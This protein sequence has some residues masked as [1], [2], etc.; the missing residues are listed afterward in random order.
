MSKAKV[1][2]WIK[3]L[4]VALFTTAICTTAYAAAID[5]ILLRWRKTSKYEDATGNLTIAV[6]YYSA[7]LVEAELQ[8]EAEKNLWTQDE[9]ERY[10]YRYLKTLN[11]AEMIPIK[12]EFVN[13]GPTMYPGPFD[14][15]IKMQIG[16]KTYEP[17]DYDKRF[18]FSFQGEK[19]GLVFF[20]RF[21][22]KT[23]KNLLDGKH[24]DSRTRQTGP[25]LLGHK[26][27][28]PVKALRGTDRRAP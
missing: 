20:N 23:G 3:I 8:S 11:L 19:D 27:R 16:N 15:M 26:E 12:V 10:K 6:T 2:S 28:R 7:E 25:L 13:N 1:S 18:N 17:A 9:L 14:K 21:D 4:T 24:D 22:P 5:N